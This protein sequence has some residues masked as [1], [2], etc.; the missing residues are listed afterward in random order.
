MMDQKQK[1]I[2]I[3]ALGVSLILNVAAAGYIGSRLVRDRVTTSFSNGLEQAP[4]PALEKAFG[5]ALASSP[6]KLAAAFAR[7]KRARKVQHEILIAPQYDMA[8]H[9]RAQ[10]DTRQKVADLLSVLHGALRETA[11]NL[12]DAERRAIPPFNMKPFRKTPTDD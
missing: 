1:R 2:L 4:S 12:P 10:A 6:G 9:A 11:T 3:T 7:L 8:E 5:D